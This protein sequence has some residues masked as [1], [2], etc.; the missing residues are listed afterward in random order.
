MH[1][2]L[3]LTGQ[4]SGI[5]HLSAICNMRISYQ[6]LAR[7]FGQALS[8]DWHSQHKTYDTYSM[9][10]HSWVGLHSHSYHRFVYTTPQYYMFML[11]RN[12]VVCMCTLLNAVQPDNQITVNSNLYISNLINS[13]CTS[14]IYRI[15]RVITPYKYL[16]GFSTDNRYIISLLTESYILLICMDTDSSHHL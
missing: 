5:Y 7:L 1:F 10:R 8:I 3:A 9:L 12:F 4:A 11:P 14:P 2:L 6:P 13:Y 15:G 16:I